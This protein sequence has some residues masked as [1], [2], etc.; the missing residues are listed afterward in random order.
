MSVH[1]GEKMSVHIEEKCQC[2]NLKSINN[3]SSLDHVIDF[4]I[5]YMWFIESREIFCTGQHHPCERTC[6]CWT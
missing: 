3:Q 4:Q 6:S 1:I 2:I 5:S